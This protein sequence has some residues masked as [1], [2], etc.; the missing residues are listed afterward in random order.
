MMLAAIILFF[1][2]LAWD[3][4]SDYQ[5]WLKGR[6]V[7]HGKEAWIRCVMLIPAIVLFT[8]AHPGNSWWHLAYTLVMCFFVFWTIFD[9]AYNVLRGFNWWFTGSNDPD[10]ADT[11]NFLQSIPLWLH[12]LIKLG[13]C[14]GG[15]FLY[16][17]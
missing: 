17:K 1:A 6:G 12:I 16:F 7:I 3:V 14:A 13:G 10:D 2:V 5:K 11:D 8:V 15:L 4:I 9:G